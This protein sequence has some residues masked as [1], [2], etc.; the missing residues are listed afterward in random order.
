MTLLIVDDNPQVRRMIRSLLEDL[1]TEVYECADGAQAVETY[2]QH[3][4]DWVLMDIEM[5]AVNGLTATRAL[6]ALDPEARILMVTNYHDD[7][8][9]TAA[10]QAGACGYVRKENLLELRR[11]LQP[12]A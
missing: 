7:A 5:G 8:L 1:L 10:A 4:P 2:A 9:R 6:K 12:A 3:H 11:W